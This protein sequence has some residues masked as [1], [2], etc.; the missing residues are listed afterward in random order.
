MKAIIVLM[1][2][3]P[4]TLLAT[5][6][7]FA[8]DAVENQISECDRPTARDPHALKKVYE[9]HGEQCD[10]IV[11]TTDRVVFKCSGGITHYYLPTMDSC[12]HTYEGVKKLM[13]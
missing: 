5:T 1:L 10:Y 3:F 2:L 12:K 13:K 7:T 8:F 9:D 4:P 11:N 6:F